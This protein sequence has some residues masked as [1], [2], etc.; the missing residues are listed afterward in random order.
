MS[1]P[2]IIASI[3]VI[4]FGLGAFLGAPWVPAFRQD[5]DELFDLAGVK[6]S[7]KFVDLGCGDG[8]VLAA[9]ARRGAVVTG[10]EV[11]PLLWLVA[12]IRLLRYGRRAKVYLRSFWSVDVG[13]FDVVYFY[14]IHHHMPRMRSQ[15][16]HQLEPDT[17]VISYMFAFE[18]VTPLQTTR[19]SFLYTLAS[20]GKVEK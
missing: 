7:T 20:F 19:N 12:R 15:L 8:K 2:W 5:F 14:L 13:A 16:I 11:N 3:V 9:A 17:K 1:W 18:G 4:S 10:F 6:K